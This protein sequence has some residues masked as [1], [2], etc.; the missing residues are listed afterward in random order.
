MALTKCNRKKK[1]EGLNM[2]SNKKSAIQKSNWK[3]QNAAKVYFLN[4]HKLVCNL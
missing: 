4:L 1:F 3:Q 2:A